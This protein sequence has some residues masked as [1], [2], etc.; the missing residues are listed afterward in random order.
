MY[1]LKI[2]MMYIVFFFALLILLALF[3]IGGFVVDNIEMFQTPFDIVLGI[4]FSPWKHTWEDV[5]FMYLV[6]GSF[7][8]G[9]T[10]IVVSV[11]FFDVKLKL[12]I[13]ALRKEVKTLEKSVADGKLMIPKVEMPVQQ[14]TLTEM[15]E[16]QADITPEDVTKSFEDTVK[17]GDFY[18]ESDTQDSGESQQE[19]KE[20]LPSEKEPEKKAT[21]DTLSEAEVLET[22]SEQRHISENTNS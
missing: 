18:K 16:E 14:N 1:G 20:E 9:M 21:Q 8:L 12:K 5:P 10:I 11:V 4:P 15:L 17:T 2:S 7:L 19:Y 13:R 22:E 6:G 3:M